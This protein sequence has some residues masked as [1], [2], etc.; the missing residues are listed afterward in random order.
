MSEFLDTLDLFWPAFAASL[1]VAAACALV[2]VH[3]VARRMVVVGAA[4]PQAA[5]FGI[6]LSFVC[7]GVPLLGD[8]DVAALA[9]EGLA[10]A[11]LALAPRWSRLGQDT[12]AGVVFAVCASGSVLVVQQIPQGLDEIRHLVE[13]NMLA[14]HGHDL[15]RIAAALVPVVVLHAGG[16]RRLVWVTFDRDS[17]AALGVRAGLWDAA[18]FA[19]LALAVASGVHATGTLFVFS[20]LVMP[21]ASA[22]LLGATGASVLAISASIGIAA[23]AAG[24]ILSWRLDTPTG[25]TCAAVAALLLAASA[26][27]AKLRNR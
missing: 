8:H 24:F 26:A 27:A 12:V 6:A 16:S 9:M 11:A 4:L 20:F 17:A 3:V 15:G 2:G 25:P 5:A 18:F 23:A 19:S 14:I 13:G 22:T 10:V 21:A 7:A 1:L